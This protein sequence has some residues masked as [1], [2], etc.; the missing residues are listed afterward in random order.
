MDI[1]KFKKTIKQWIWHWG[2][3]AQLYD[4]FS[5]SNLTN[6]S[7]CAAF[8]IMDPTSEFTSSFPFVKEENIPIARQY[9]QKHPIYD[10]LVLGKV[11]VMAKCEN[12]S[13]NYHKYWLIEWKYN[14]QLEAQ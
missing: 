6:K 3:N 13:N 11:E 5:V 1:F 14:P 4:T 8:Q 10:G 9:I 2:I 7:Y 12:G